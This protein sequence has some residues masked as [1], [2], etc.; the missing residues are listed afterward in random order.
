MHSGFVWPIRQDRHS[1]TMCT[2]YLVPATAWPLNNTRNILICSRN[3][4][5]RA[6][7]HHSLSFFVPSLPDF[8]SQ[9]L[10]LVF[11]TCLCHRQPFLKQSSGVS[12]LEAWLVLPSVKAKGFFSL[13]SRLRPNCHSLRIQHALLMYP[14]AHFYLSF[15]HGMCSLDF[16]SAQPTNIYWHS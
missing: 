4:Q 7:H 15:D 11:Q 12:R 3:R 10:N 1:N 2:I 5:N 9:W 14:H 8:P 13:W 16:S 6:M